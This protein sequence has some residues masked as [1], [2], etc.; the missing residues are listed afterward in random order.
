[1]GTEVTSPPVSAGLPNMQ[2]TLIQSDSVLSG[3]RVQLNTDLSASAL[4]GPVSQNNQIPANWWGY[5]MPPEPSAFN[6][7]LSQVFDTAGKAPMP[8]A[9]SPIV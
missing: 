9:G 7:G 3:G 1:V 2:S 6:P 8:S 4:L 5:G